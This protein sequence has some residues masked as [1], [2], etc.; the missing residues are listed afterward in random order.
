MY[1]VIDLSSNTCLFTGT[2][3]ECENFIR[4]NPNPNLAMTMFMY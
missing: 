1:K 3:E 2:I 4:N